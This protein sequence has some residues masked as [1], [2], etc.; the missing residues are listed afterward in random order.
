MEAVK[1]C[2]VVW[3]MTHTFSPDVLAKNPDLAKQVKSKKSATPSGRGHGFTDDAQ[4]YERKK[5][6]KVY[7]PTE[8]RAILRD[9]TNHYIAMLRVWG[10]E[11]RV[12]QK[13]KAACEL[14]ILEA[15]E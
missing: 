2:R 5:G 4:T 10:T 12:Q 13:A 8:R 6:R 15:S 11:T 14:V 1:I 7:T 3:I 9:M